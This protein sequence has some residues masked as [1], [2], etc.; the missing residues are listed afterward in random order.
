[1]KVSIVATV[2][3]SCLWSAA[4]AA[5]PTHSG[6]GAVVHAT[7]SEFWGVHIGYT[8]A[9]SRWGLFFDFKARGSTGGEYYDNISQSLA[10]S[11]GDPV[12]GT[13]YSGLIISMG[14][15]YS[16]HRR[17]IVNL[18]LGYSALDKYQERYDDMHILGENGSYS[19]MDEQGSMQ[20]N[21]TASAVLNPWRSLALYVGYDSNPESLVVGVG[22]AG[23]R[24]F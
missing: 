14:P 7:D 16:L 23:L 8:G 18:G 21:L 5:P 4:V 10:D 1:V 19:V 12:T 3:V 17:L 20:L 24:G 6:Y 15:S 11:W 13:S 2:L 9:N 22:L